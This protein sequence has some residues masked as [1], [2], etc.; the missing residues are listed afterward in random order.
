MTTSLTKKNSPNKPS[1]LVVYSVA[2]NERESARLT[3]PEFR[4]EGEIRIHHGKPSVVI[5]NAELCS[6]VTNLLEKAQATEPEITWCKLDKKGST[7][8]LSRTVEPY[9]P[10][11]AGALAEKM[12]ELCVT[13]NLGRNGR[14]VRF[15]TENVFEEMLRPRVKGISEKRPKQETGLQG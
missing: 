4:R 3:R 9:E 15:A 11:Y 1:T 14:R 8:R 10:A 7:I 12:N 13:S 6:L 2:S 5:A